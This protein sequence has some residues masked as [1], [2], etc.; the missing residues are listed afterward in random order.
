MRRLLISV[1]VLAFCTANGTAQKPIGHMKSGDAMVRGSVVLNGNSAA[2]MSGAFIE[3]AQTAAVVTLERGGELTVC[4]NSA[5]TITASAS[6]RDQLVGVSSGTIE[7]HYTLAAN[8]DTIMTPDFRLLL[9]GPGDFHFGIS[10]GTTGDVC[11]QGFPDS[12]ASLV[13]NELLGDGSYQVKP[14]ERIRFRNGSVANAAPNPN[15]NPNPNND[16]QGP[17]GCP[18]AP[19]R[20]AAV[21][22]PATELGFP[23]Q[24]SQ[25][26]AVAIASGK[27]APEPPAV[28]GIPAPAKTGE[29]Q[30]Q[31][32]APMVFRGDAAP[33]VGPPMPAIT[34]RSQLKPKAFPTFPEIAVSRPEQPV[35]TSP[36]IASAAKPRKRNIFQKF[37]SM[38]ARLF[39]SGG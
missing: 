16:Q 35:P 30:L 11:V 5:V 2:L 9:T 19:A 18:V 34:P 17:C 6:G 38:I 7:T 39:G 13:V 31:I 22:K 36:T 10:L 3:S 32:D 14:G 33:P 28:A 15:P 27:P 4:P 26:A 1:L 8:S 37:G 25:Q 20:N 21:P 23:E 24:Q 29:I 12:T